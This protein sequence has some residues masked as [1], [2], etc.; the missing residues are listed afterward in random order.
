MVKSTVCFDGCVSGGYPLAMNHTTCPRPL[1]ALIQRS[2][3]VLGIVC[4]LLTWIVLILLQDV[5][6]FSTFITKV[7]IAVT[8]ALVLYVAGLIQ[9]RPSF[10]VGYGFGLCGTFLIAIAGLWI[11][12]TMKDYGER[13][14]FEKG[15][16]ERESESGIRVRMVDDLLH[17]Y[18][19]TGWSKPQ[20]EAL[21]GRPPASPYFKDHCEWLYW[22]GPERGYFSID[23]EWL[24]LQFKADIVSSAIVVRD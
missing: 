22:L 13:T 10:A 14:S 2:S 1:K 3:L 6:P 12:L 15:L 19:L 16:W 4:G 21:L 24:C 18:P 17:R 23:S 11:V 7:A 20:V 5:L 9:Q 8:L